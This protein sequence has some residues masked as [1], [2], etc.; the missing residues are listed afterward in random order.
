M[1]LILITKNWNGAFIKNTKN[2]NKFNLCLE[3][4]C[5]EGASSSYIAA[6]LLKE[7]GK[8]VC[9]DPLTDQFFNENLT[10]DVIEANSQ[11]KFF[12]NQYERF[13][14]TCKEYLE[15]GK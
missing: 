12:K 15:N 5:F 3:I 8:L 2:I 7:N 13:Q 14:D 10:E 9:V 11:R 1:E 6:N 4:G